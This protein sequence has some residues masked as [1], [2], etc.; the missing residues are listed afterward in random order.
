LVKLPILDQPNGKA[1]N[2]TAEEQTLE[3]HRNR[4]DLQ[5]FISKPMHSWFMSNFLGI[6][7][8]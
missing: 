3:E 6:N 8:W 5:A 4:H 7:D 1:F 2:S